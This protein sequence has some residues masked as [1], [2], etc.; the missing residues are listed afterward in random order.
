MGRFRPA[1]NL[2]TA[3]LNLFRN[4]ADTMGSLIVMSFTF[5][6]LGIVFML[7][8]NVNSVVKEAQK[9]FD[10]IGI[11]LMDEAKPSS[12][13]TM[14]DDIKNI[15]GVKTVKY[16]NKDVA[17][18][19]WKSEWKEDAYLLEGIGDSPLPNA[20][21]LTLNDISYTKSV[22][23]IVSSY[24]GVEEIKYYR[25]E[26]EKMLNISK[27][28]SQIGFGIITVL[29]VLCFFVVSNTIKIAV[30]SRQVEINIM[31]YVGAKN[32]FIRGPFITEGILIGL[33]SAALSSVIV[34]LI[35]NYVMWNIGISAAKMMNGASLFFILDAN[36]LV[37]DFA[38]IA[39][40]LGIGIG[41]LG[42]I[43]STRK[44]LKV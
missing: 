29:L 36:Q 39:V 30:N 7:V 26:V 16:V 28:I 23:E 8:M 41:A 27:V 3:F 14:Y 2:K 15:V 17:W 42:A 31:K 1:Y 6:I 18:K 25:E 10:E 19:R 35:Y 22:A 33:I 40:V 43:N 34:Y 12:I 44:H 38:Y 9:N 32:Y 11:F 24:E 5:A 37:G 20:F 13:Q 21:Y 4:G